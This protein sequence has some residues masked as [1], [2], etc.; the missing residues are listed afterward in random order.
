MASSL[1][2]ELENLS[3]SEEGEQW[4]AGGAEGSAFPAPVLCLF[5]RHARP[6]VMGVA[7]PGRPALY[8]PEAP[9][10]GITEPGITKRSA[11]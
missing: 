5:V 8:S 4:R 2:M 3:C 9:E 10:P 1:N 7:L 11:E 6:S